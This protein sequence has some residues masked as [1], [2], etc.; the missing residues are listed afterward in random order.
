M[1]L[2][3]EINITREWK[4]SNLLGTLK[5]I[6]RTAFAGQSPNLTGGMKIS[7][8]VGES[9]K[10]VYEDQGALVTFPPPAPDVA[11]DLPP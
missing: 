2:R 4:K 1:E 3:S 7:I 9:R 6:L 5:R 8:G 10:A 11:W